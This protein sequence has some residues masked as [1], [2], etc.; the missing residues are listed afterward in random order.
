M[1]RKKKIFPKNGILFGLYNFPVVFSV[2]FLF[3]HLRKEVIAMKKPH[4]S[5]NLLRRLC[6]AALTLAVLFS[7][8]PSGF[9][10]SYSETYLSLY[11]AEAT[12]EEGK[13]SKDAERFFSNISAIYIILVIS[14]L[15]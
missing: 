4:V 6:A 13:F 12:M 14:F 10:E 5:A 3:D 15:I 11:Y 2:G 9:A 1:E 8:M 7:A